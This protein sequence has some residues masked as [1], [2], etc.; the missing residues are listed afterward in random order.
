MTPADRVLARL[1]AV[2]QTGPGRWLA[3]CPSH[4]DRRPSLSVRETEDGRLLLYCF[5]GCGACDVVAAVGLELGD[6]FP[7]RLDVAPSSVRRRREAPRIPAADALALLDVEALT[8]QLCA[9]RLAQGEPLERHREDLE[10]AGQRIGAV[11]EA[12]GMRP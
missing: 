4:E 1:E 8:V 2:R 12:W 6:L 9:H 10:T 7:E 5:A 3:R 11:A